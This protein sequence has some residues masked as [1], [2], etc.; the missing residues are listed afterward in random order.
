MP[1]KKIERWSAR[2][3]RAADEAR[4]YF[5]RRSRTVGKPIKRKAL[6]TTQKI[7]WTLGLFL[8]GFL[9]MYPSLFDNLRLLRTH[10][11]FKPLRVALFTWACFVI[12]IASAYIMYSFEDLLMLFG[13]GVFILI[14]IGIVIDILRALW[15][16]DVSMAALEAGINKEVVQKHFDIKPP[17]SKRYTPP[18][19]AQHLSGISDIVV[20]VLLALLWIFLFVLL[21]II[22]FDWFGA[23]EVSFKRELPAAI[24]L[25]LR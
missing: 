3:R 9:V 12:I 21:V 22:V 7:R 13:A 10:P 11:Y 19:K 18:T 1:K 6:D 17:V 20:N 25:F 5:E 4:A 16:H 23:F 24:Q 14:G 8:P 15:R 2:K